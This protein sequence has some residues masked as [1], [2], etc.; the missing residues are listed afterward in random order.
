MTPL[1]G[2]R[3]SE[4]TANSRI[5]N[6]PFSGPWGHFGQ[7]KARYLSNFSLRYRAFLVA[8]TGFEPATSGYSKALFSLFRARL[9]A[10]ELM[11][12]YRLQHGASHNARIPVNASIKRNTSIS[13]NECIP[14]KASK[15]LNAC[16]S[17]N[18]FIYSKEEQ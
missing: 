10:V 9:E 4:I 14:L 1:V 17:R 3:T 11:V 8:G 5:I 2:T 18:T 15:K 12:F 13:R 16:V 6:G 7:N